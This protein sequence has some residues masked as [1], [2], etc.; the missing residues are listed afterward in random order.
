MSRELKFSVHS[1]AF[2]TSLLLVSGCSSFNYDWNH[3][4]ATPPPLF[5][6]SGRWQG[7]WRSEVTGHTDQ[8]RCIITRVDM[9]DYEARFKAKYHGI[10][11]FSYTVPLK[12]VQKEDGFRF[13]GAADLGA[14]AGGMYQYE[15]H[16]EP[17]NFFSTYSSKDD[18]GTFQMGRP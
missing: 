9:D 13:S 5:G 12:V 2:L 16:A 11:S 3:A 1:L 14:M 18:H 10:L 8:L 17:T 6:I 4:A 15:G 7:T